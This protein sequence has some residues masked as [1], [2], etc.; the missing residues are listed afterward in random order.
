MRSTVSSSAPLRQSQPFQTRM[1]CAAECGRWAANPLEP[2]TWPAGWVSAWPRNRLTWPA[3]WSTWSSV[4]HG[5]PPAR[6]GSRRHK[7]C[8][9]SDEGSH[10][11]PSQPAGWPGGHGAGRLTDQSAGQLRGLGNAKNSGVQKRDYERPLLL[12]FPL[13][14][15][16]RARQPNDCLTGYGG[17]PVRGREE[18]VRV[19]DRKNGLD[20]LPLS[21]VSL[22]ASQLAS[23]PAHIELSKGCLASQPNSRST[24][25]AGGSV[26]D[27]ERGR[28]QEVRRTGENLL[29]LSSGGPPVKYVFHF[30]Y[31]WKIGGRALCHPPFPWE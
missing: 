11:P 27:S 14:P 21:L 22:L 17:R 19:E 25:H 12:S 13:P 3:G 26:A 4:S 18:G 7:N 29:P 2:G 30:Y 28:W 5:S 1:M 31:L 6:D 23:Q 9:T 8:C 20:F 16:G 15:G 24:G 10:P